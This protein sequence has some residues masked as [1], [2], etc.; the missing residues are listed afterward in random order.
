M[1]KVTLNLRLTKAKGNV[2]A[3]VCPDVCL[4]AQLTKNCVQIF[5]KV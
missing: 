5:T 2:F 3:R 1:L 4:L